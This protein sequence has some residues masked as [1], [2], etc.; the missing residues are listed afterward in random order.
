M[1][2]TEH[3]QSAHGWL[4][5]G[6]DPQNSILRVLSGCDHEVLGVLE[7]KTS[8][9]RPYLISKCLFLRGFLPLFESRTHEIEFCWALL[10]SSHPWVPWV[11]SASEDIKEF[12]SFSAIFG[13]KCPL[14][15]F[16]YFYKPSL[17]QWNPDLRN[18]DLRDSPYL[19]N[20]SLLTD[21]HWST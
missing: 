11:R 19:R 10:T 8:Q 4:G 18:S 21:F 6:R 1:S 2:T 12:V 17:I 20:K 15:E 5:V 3:T 13:S 9:T 14:L 16:F 7:A